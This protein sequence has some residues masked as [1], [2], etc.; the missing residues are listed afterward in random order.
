MSRHVQST[1]L[2]EYQKE[3]ER[4]QRIVRKAEKE[5]WIFPE[6]VVPKI[7]RRLTK[8]DVE[9]IK[10]IKPADLYAKGTQID[11]ST[12]EIITPKTTKKAPK[13]TPN[14]TQKLSKNL[15]SKVKSTTKSRL[16]GSAEQE[17]PEHLSDEQ[18][19]K[20]RSQA[21]KKAW[22]T[23][24]K[25]GFTKKLKPVLTEEEKKQRRILAGKK[26]WETRRAKM[27]EEEYKDFVDSF[28]IRMQA[29]KPK[30]EL[31]EAME[32]L[33][34]GTPIEDYPTITVVE[35]VQEKLENLNR[36]YGVVDNLRPELEG[37]KRESD[38]PFPIEKRKAE[39]LRLF[40]QQVEYYGDELYL[41]EEYL[42]RKMGDIDIELDI[43]RYDSK[44]EK[45]DASLV[46]LAVIINEG[47]LSPWSAERMSFMTEYYDDYEVND[48]D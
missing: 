30:N 47:A 37:L 20:I 38:P 16:K 19:A 35:K 28:K 1:T 22:E 33:K 41:Y 43:I 6:D 29:K 32:N 23:R 17:E 36:V 3:Q 8:L 46:H 34:E 40:E 27:D 45:V 14:I 18:L 11:L 2:K 10:A 12:G 24:Y 39:I 9:K 7:P 13:T 48:E 4:L 5:G 26:A 15:P 44:Q 25:K 31:V 42:L 21:G